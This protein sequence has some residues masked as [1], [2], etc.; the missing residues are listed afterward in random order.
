MKTF[1]DIVQ[2]FTLAIFGWMVMV[3]IL[4]LGV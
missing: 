1:L 3:G 4:I 2:V